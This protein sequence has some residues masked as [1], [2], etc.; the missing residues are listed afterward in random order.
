MK[1]GAI[2]FL[3]SLVLYLSVPLVLLKLLL[4]GCGNRAY[5]ERI[6]ERF[7]CVAEPKSGLPV[8]WVH[9][10]SVGEVQASGA[11]VKRL[12]RS[13]PGCRVLLTTI[14]P[15][16][17]A[18][19]EKLFSGSVE[20]RYLPYDLPHGINL[21]LRRIKPRLLVIL[22]TEIWPN[23]LHCCSRRGVPAVLVNG[24]LSAT[25]YRG[26]LRLRRFTASTV[27]LLDHIAAR[28]AE[29]AGRFLA[30]GAD[31]A[32]VSIAGDLKF[33]DEM[34]P[35]TSAQAQSLRRS[36][37]AG[38][39][40]WIAA[41]THEGEE[42]KVLDAFRG[43]RESLAD[44]LLIIAPRHPERFDRV[45]DLCRRRGLEVSRRS[46]A[47]G[48]VRRD[49]DVYLL[50]TL[51]ELPL[52][53]ACADAA[54]VGGSLV[55]AGGHNVLEAARLGVPLVSGAHTGNFAE[56]IG[57]F[58]AADAIMTVNDATQLAA[59][60]T[61]LLTDAELGRARG[62]RGQRLVQEHRGALNSVMEILEGYLG[63]E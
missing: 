43:V 57:L 50:D 63:S 28:S 48:A 23:L 36:L 14:T 60:V 15:T 40:V 13:Y 38:R 11:L 18:Q 56:I 41:S 5:L 30:L 17:A 2:R 22:E 24:R 61:R 32:A 49:T 46:D 19:V 53:Y 34:P 25:S 44:C 9:A 31:P 33:D 55:P 12:L 6:P 7:G 1:T 4:R 59:A 27:R 39:P 51:G 37:A 21:F 10:V 45:Y 58:K 16:G 54:F 20:H 29:D 35:E 62:E 8:I 3:Y 52:F 26:Y 42:D 47:A